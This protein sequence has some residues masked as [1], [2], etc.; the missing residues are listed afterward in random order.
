MAQLVDILALSQALEG[1]HVTIPLADEDAPSNVS[2][3]GQADVQLSFKADPVQPNGA[4]IWV[5][6]DNL[7]VAATSAVECAESM[8]ATRPLGKIQ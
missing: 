3:A 1:D 6:A 4:W 5:A 2:A 8:T 7:R